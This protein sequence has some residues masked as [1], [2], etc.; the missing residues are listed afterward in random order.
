MVCNGDCFGCKY[1]DCMASYQEI[2]KLDYLE[3]KKRREGMKKY[4]ES[5]EVEMRERKINSS[6]KID[7][8]R[9]KGTG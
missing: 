7:G 4:L 9:A 1:P 2:A 8:K 3:R 6:T 5:V